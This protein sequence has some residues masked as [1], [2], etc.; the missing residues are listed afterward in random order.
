MSV[1]DNLDQHISYDGFMTR[2]APV[3]VINYKKCQLQ[4]EFVGQT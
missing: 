1:F 2:L 3:S 4:K